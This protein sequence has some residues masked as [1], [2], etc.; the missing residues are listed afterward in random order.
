MASA[1][2]RT[3]GRKA[4]VSRAAA[5]RAAMAI[6]DADGL[7]AVTMQRIGQRLGVEAMS[8]YR[9]VRNKD[10]ILGGLVDLVF[11]EIEIPA[12][13][14]DW[15]SAMRQ[16]ANSARAALSRHP[17]A[18]GLLESRARP[19]P[20]N[21]RHHDAVLGILLKAGFSAESA[22]HA[23]NL[24]DS[25]VYGFA[26]QERTLPFRTADELAEVGE[27]ILALMPP[28]EYPILAA[29]GRELFDA[30]FDYGGEFAFGLELILDG[31]TERAAGI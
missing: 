2:A 24:L 27:A 8:L 21:L 3:G 30:G 17:W 23:Y 26:L 12:D 4:R 19:G 5:L 20:A 1:V 25:F 13:A 18:I 14:P 16:R 11:E 28:D 15:Q 22:T 31:L 7:D 9:H 29:V 10:E 6:A